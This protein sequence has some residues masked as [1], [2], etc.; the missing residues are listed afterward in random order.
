MRCSI[1]HLALELKIFSDGALSFDVLWGNIMGRSV[2]YPHP[3][4]ICIRNFANTFSNFAKITTSFN[5]YYAIDSHE[6]FKF[7]LPF[8]TVLPLLYYIR[9][10][11]LMTDNFSCE[12]TSQSALIT[13]VLQLVT[14]AIV[15]GLFVSSFL[16]KEKEY[17]TWFMTF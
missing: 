14:F 15:G 2:E 10:T 8:S 9:I 5:S 17:I 12:K 4:S 1:E 6:F 7:L 13:V 11:Y 16:D 3:T